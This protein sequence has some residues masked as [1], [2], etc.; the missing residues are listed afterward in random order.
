MPY[1]I[2]LGSRGKFNDCRCEDL[3]IL[4][5]CNFHEFRRAKQPVLALLLPPNEMDAFVR[6][7][8]TR[9]MCFLLDKLYEFSLLLLTA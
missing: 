8:K 2:D 7:E 4:L 6:E 9:T 5:F 3:V 1:S